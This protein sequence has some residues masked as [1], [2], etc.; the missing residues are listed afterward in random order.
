VGTSLAHIGTDYYWTAGSTIFRFTTALPIDSLYEVYV[1]YPS[2]SVRSASVQHIISHASGSTTVSIDQ[3]TGGLGIFELLGTF[4][5]TQGDTTL[6]VRNTQSGSASVDAIKYV[7]V[8]TVQPIT[9]D[10]SDA[11]LSG[12]WS[13]S[14]GLPHFGTNYLWTASTA[15]I[16]FI[17]LLGVAGD[18]EVLVTYQGASSRSSSVPHII[19]HTGGTTTVNVDQ[20]TGGYPSFTSLGV[21]TFA[22]GSAGRVLITTTGAAAGVVG[23]DAV[24]FEL[25]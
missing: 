15:T 21:F 13:T 9:V 8:D 10:N 23:A 7:R 3:R 12:S 18:Y 22:L 2:H 5:F 4:E 17:P 1:T 11:V 14:S 19:T 25:Q 16:T 6:I 24:R 20:T